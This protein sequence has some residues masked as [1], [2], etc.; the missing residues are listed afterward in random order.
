MIVPLDSRSHRIV[1][2]PAA[3]KSES[4]NHPLEA[5][6]QLQGWN[7][8]RNHVVVV[9]SD[10]GISRTERF[11][12]LGCAALAQ[13]HCELDGYAPGFDISLPLSLPSAHRSEYGGI[14]GLER[15]EAIARSSRPGRPRRYFLTFRGSMYYPS[16]AE[17]RELLLPLARQSTAERPVAI[18][19]RCAGFGHR[20][21]AELCD[22]LKNASS[23]APPYLELLNTTFALVPAG[24]SPA[25]MR[26]PEVLAAGAVPVFVS[27]DT[28]SASAYVRPYDEV[29]PWHEVSLHF[30]WEA[31]D[32]I[33]RVLERIPPHKV[34]KMQAMAQHVWKQHF[35]PPN[36][37][38]TFFSLLEERA[39]FRFRRERR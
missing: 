19:G 27:G 16:G 21:A 18:F 17:R 11:Q 4:S 35:R 28:A 37:V 34:A 38:A 3:I 10:R 2:R 39:S 29:V 20:G 13:S 12:W 32:S 24:E 31:G 1:G 14:L 9:R 26:L 22:A 25:S 36:E 33:V 6:R 5:L 23:A 7:G 15:L 30:P 8:G